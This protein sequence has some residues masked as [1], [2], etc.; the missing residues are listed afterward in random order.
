MSTAIEKR[1][2]ALP[3]MLFDRLDDD[4]IKAELEGKIP[5]VLTY[6]F[7]QD[8]KEV[9]GI[10][11]AGVDEA[12]REMAK[13]GE[14]IR[15]MSLDCNE[16]ETDYLFKGVC[17]RYAV[18]NDGREVQLDSRIGLKRQPKCYNNGK[19]NPFAYEQGGMKALRNAN[20]R[21]ISEEVIQGVIEYAKKSG[22]VKE[23]KPEPTPQPPQPKPEPKQE[24][25]KQDIRTQIRNLC[26]ELNNNDASKAKSYL[27]E[28]S[29]QVNVKFIPEDE[30]EA[31]VKKALSDHAVA[32]PPVEVFE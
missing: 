19:P 29:G 20:R 32:F 14:V 16:T 13:R 25:E 10:S 2:D 24:P 6:H 8:G 17:S 27:R 1:D 28:I 3:F 30:L 12:V 21:L 4:I 7:N 5:T 11:K 15:E 9:W 22:K 31:V 26:L 23:V 18:S